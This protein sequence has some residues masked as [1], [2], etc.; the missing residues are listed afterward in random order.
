MTAN[1][2]LHPAMN[3]A[4]SNLT[5]ASSNLGV[6][7]ILRNQLSVVS[8]FSFLDGLGVGHVSFQ[9]GCLEIRFTDH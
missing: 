2:F 9:F 3:K 8:R 6:I 4:P 1:Q 5:K 7:P